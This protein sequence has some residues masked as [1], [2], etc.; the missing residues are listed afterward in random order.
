MGTALAPRAT[1]G[2]GACA[3]LCVA[4]ALVLGACFIALAAAFWLRQRGEPAGV[5]CWRFPTSN[6]LFIEGRLRCWELGRARRA[7]AL[8]LDLHGYTVNST[9]QRGLSRFEQ[10]AGPG[11]ALVAW[12]NGVRASWN[13]G[14]CCGLA[15]AL[16]IDDVAFLRALI[17]RLRARHPTIRH[18]YATGHSNGCMMAQRLALDAPDALAAVA[19]MAGYLQAQPA[20]IPAPAPVALLEVHCR[21]DPVV[22]FEPRAGEWPGAEAN[23]EAWRQLDEC[24]RA[25]RSTRWSNDSST[26]IEYTRCAR[27]QTH[28]RAA[29]LSLARCGHSPYRP[30]N[31]S[32]HS[33]R[34]NETVTE[35]AWAF[36][37]AASAAT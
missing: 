14:S 26:L 19:C 25:S 20:R 15:A 29:L 35:V 32:A 5:N 8:V 12:P 31:P 11:G 13:A 24:E 28:V 23:L 9:Q 33:S 2:R 3:R 16:G 34:G 6:S 1:A 27:G 30:R 7:T 21:D 37:L 36:M 10:V 18:V 17:A 4:C 22:T